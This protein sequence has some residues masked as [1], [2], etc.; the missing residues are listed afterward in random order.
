MLPLFADRKVRLDLQKRYKITPYPDGTY[1]IEKLGIEEEGTPINAATLNPIVNHVN[2]DTIHVSRTEYEALER[3]ITRTEAYLDIDSRGVS[4][5]QARFADTYDGQNDPVLQLDETKTY[6][7]TGI[8]ASVSAVTVQV[9]SVAGFSVGQEITIASSGGVEDKQ[10]T[11]IDKNAKTITF[12]SMQ[13]SHPK[14]AL[15]ARSTVERDTA[16]RLM[17]VGSWGTYTVTITEP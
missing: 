12:P 15:I 17:K 3:R 13:F 11:A 4:G 1:D 8:D 16:N 14:G 7:L 2:D 9:A 5:A 6:S 10:I